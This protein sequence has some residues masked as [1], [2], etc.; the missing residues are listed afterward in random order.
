M[1]SERIDAL[2]I[3]YVSDVF[4]VKASGQIS[5]RGLVIG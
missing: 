4:Y 2:F 1:K 3:I 5:A